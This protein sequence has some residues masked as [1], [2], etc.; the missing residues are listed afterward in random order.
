MQCVREREREAESS[1]QVDCSSS[2]VTIVMFN[3]TTR[4]RKIS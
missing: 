2:G 3:L 4:P 1:E